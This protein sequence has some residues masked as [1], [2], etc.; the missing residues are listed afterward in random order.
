VELQDF[1]LGILDVVA[2][3]RLYAQIPASFFQ[4]LLFLL[5]FL[6]MMS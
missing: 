6:R 3:Q 1:C 4:L 2:Y 5:H